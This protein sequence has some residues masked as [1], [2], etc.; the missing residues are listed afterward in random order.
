[1]AA[2]PPTPPAGMMTNLLFPSVSNN[3]I[4]FPA[5]SDSLLVLLEV[6]FDTDRV[7]DVLDSSFGDV[8]S[9]VG[10]QKS[11]FLVTHAYDFDREDLLNVLNVDKKLFK[12]KNTVV[13]TVLKAF[14]TFS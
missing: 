4:S 1:V 6:I 13:E 10:G 2:A 11:G 3:L 8:A 14:R 7:D 9:T 5:N 12:P